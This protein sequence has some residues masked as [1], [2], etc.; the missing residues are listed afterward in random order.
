MRKIMRLDLSAE[1]PES[2][3]YYY[4]K[5]VL[6]AEEYEIRDAM[7]RLRAVGREDSVWI[8]VL[9]CA[10]L[11]ALEN[12]RL[13]SPTIDELNFFA[14]RL[15]SMTDEDKTVFDAVLRQV[16]PGDGKGSLVG[17]KELINSTYGLDGVMTASNI[18][19][20]EQLGQFVIESDLD[21]EINALPDKAIPLLDRRKIGERFRTIYG[22]EYINGTAIFAGDYE[23]PEIYDGKALPEMEES[24]SFVFRLKV[25]E[26][27]TGGTAET[28]NDAEWISLPTNIAMAKDMAIKHHEPSI[29]S[30]VCYA[31]ESS[32]PQ[33][34]L[35]MF[36]SMLNF[37]KLNR[38][39]WK[40]DLLSPAD[41]VK[42]KAAFA[43]ERP[44]C[45]AEALDIAE[46]IWQYEFYSKP[47]NSDQ[48]FKIYL[49]HHLDS[50][51]DSEW[52]DTLLT[53]NERDELLK[54]LGASLTDYGAISARG[55]SL[56]ELVPYREPEIR[57]EYAPAT[58]GVETAEAEP[59]ENEEIQ[60]GG[61]QL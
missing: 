34:T 43:A 12:V 5:L 2:D 15:V 8:S 29:E 52:L 53:Q 40:F 23:R 17:M 46:T 4:A 9:E 20:D 16:I 18:Y 42:C 57:A 37:D 61:M 14:K 36:S 51:F 45:I 1:I 54:R 47:E 28:E 33:I 50:R 24:K 41:Q 6:P 55:R 60:I 49:K 44:E 56:Y 19:N 27:P 10:D 58:T 32:I 11:P 39:A 13:D 21:D 35:D 25:G 48:F 3:G 59:E 38:L 22:C 26:Y 30:C 7:Q 31:F